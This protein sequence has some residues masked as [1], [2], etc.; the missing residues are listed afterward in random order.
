[1]RSFGKFFGLAGLRCFALSD[2]L[3]VERLQAQLD[4]GQWPAQRSNMAFAH[5]LMPSGKSRCGA[6]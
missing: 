4:H 2:A 6:G 5:W 1:M 3:T